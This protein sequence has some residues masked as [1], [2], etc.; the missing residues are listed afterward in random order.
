IAQPPAGRR[1][2]RNP[3]AAPG[4]RAGRGFEYIATQL[5]L[6]EDQRTQA[7]AI[8]KDARTQVAALAPQLKDQRA[9]VQD[10]IKKNADD[11]TIQN[12]AAKDGDLHA[13]LAAIRI[14][15]MAK[16]YALLTPEQKDKLAQLRGGL[17]GLFGAGPRGWGR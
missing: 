14:K 2:W 9:A 6:T 1:A 7:Q 13:R 8:I 15:S 11:N 17:Q 16:F 3:D 5:N 12:L 10:A 4:Q